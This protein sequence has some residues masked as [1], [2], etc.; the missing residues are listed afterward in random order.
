MKAIEVI[1]TARLHLGFYNFLESNTAYGSIGVSIDRPVARVVVKPS[2]DLVVNNFTD[3]KVEDVVELVTSKIGISNIEINIYSAIP[4]HV[5][6]GST[7]QLSLAIAYAINKLFNL[8]YSIRD[9]A[10]LLGRGL[11]SG[12]G[13]AAFEKGGFI[14]DSGRF[15]N[16]NK[17]LHEP[18]KGDD[19][20][21][22]VYWAKLPRNWYFIT[23]V[24]MNI[25]GLSERE[26]KRILSLPE[27]PPIEFQYE[28]YK[29]LLLEM[30]PAISERNA[31]KFGKALTKIQLLTG[32]YFSRH[33]QGIF[34]CKETE[35]IVNLLLKYGVYGVGQSSWGPVA[36]GII[37]DRK[38]ARII[39]N[40]VLRELNNKGIKEYM[41]FI[42][43]PNNRGATVKVVG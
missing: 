23:I 35:T 6:L 2:K 17:I 40:N 37:D 26:E 25:Q 34:C 8:G 36:Y 18:K 43:K 31:K 5:G 3:V 33:Q 10:A 15:L 12:I 30:I 29:T 11:V 28:L 38:K 42:A 22:V 4:R 27:K 41:A 7:T 13:T 14:V 1:T 20:P 24:P 16:N 9:L 39:M 19:L 32:K 21:R